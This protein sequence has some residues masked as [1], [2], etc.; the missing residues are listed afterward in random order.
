[1]KK[2]VVTWIVIAV[3]SITLCV[4]IGCVVRN[5][6]SQ[7]PQEVAKENLR[8]GSV[9]EES[10]LISI[11]MNNFSGIEKMDVL[12]SIKSQEG[13]Y[14]VQAVITTTDGKEENHNFTIRY[15]TDSYDVVDE[16]E[17]LEEGFS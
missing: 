14:Q 7:T 13:V 12:Q 11:I 17:T 16:N 9:P 4:V 3:C 1:M 10:G 2:R 6:Q 8:G 5:N 15:K